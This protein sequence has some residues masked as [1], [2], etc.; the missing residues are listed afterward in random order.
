MAVT[1]SCRCCWVLSESSRHLHRYGE[2]CWVYLLLTLS[3][4]AIIQ[5]TVMHVL[6]FRTSR[7]IIKFIHACK[8]HVCYMHAQMLLVNLNEHSTPPP[9]K[10]KILHY[11]RVASVLLLD[12][13]QAWQRFMRTNCKSTTT[14]SPTTSKR[15]TS[16]VVKI[17]WGTVQMSCLSWCGYHVLCVWKSCG[18]HVLCV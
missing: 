13:T 14:P 5:S 16:I 10:K 4:L 1:P 17:R 9:P 6:K 8:M 15:R 7:G 3:L 18:Y 11:F 12:T 2:F